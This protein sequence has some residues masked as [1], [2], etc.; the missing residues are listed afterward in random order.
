MK[1]LLNIS[2]WQYFPE[3]NNSNHQLL[4]TAVK[5]LLK[6]ILQLLAKLEH[7]LLYE[8][9]TDINVY[10]EQDIKCCLRHTV[11]GSMWASALKSHPK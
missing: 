5:L 2:G 4:L 7:I 9:S 1:Q 11:S 10:A 3:Q 8:S 6:Q